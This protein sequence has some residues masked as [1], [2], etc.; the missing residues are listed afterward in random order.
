[1]W[2]LLGLLACGGGGDTGAECPDA[3][4]DGVC[5]GQDTCPG[6]DDAEDRDGDGSPDGCQ[7]DHL[8]SFQMIGASQ[9]P[10]TEHVEAQ[11][12]YDT[13]G[14]ASTWTIF[15]P[16]LLLSETA[17]GEAEIHGLAGWWE[18]EERLTDGVYEPVTLRLGSVEA[19]ELWS[20]PYEEV[21]LEGLDDLQSAT[22]IHVVRVEA[23]GWDAFES[24]LTLALEWSFY[25]VP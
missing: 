3:D 1:M 21:D 22:D 19:E 5:D 14:A 4:E 24:G 10:L 11:L 16:P 9:P 12:A 17:P 15:E 18:V 25:G 6:H 20:H 8:A 13:S 23:V 2:A 7:R